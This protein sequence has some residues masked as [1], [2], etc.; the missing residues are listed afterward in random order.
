MID[1]HPASLRKRLRT[2]LG[3]SSP[4]PPISCPPLTF[5]VWLATTPLV[6][7][8]CNAENWTTLT[9]LDTCR[10]LSIEANQVIHVR[11]IALATHPHTSGGRSPHPA[12]SN[13]R[14]DIA[15]ASL[16]T[17]Q[18]K[19]GSR[20]HHMSRSA[21]LYDGKQWGAA[22]VDRGSCVEDSGLQFWLAMAAGSSEICA[23]QRAASEPYRMIGRPSDRALPPSSSH[24]AAK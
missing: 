10:R 7:P 22:F 20:R 18:P 19:S 6:G 24:S 17:T 8:L 23:F 21:R 3:Y 9:G 2:Y 11:P 12:S 15:A 13:G 1:R 16:H 4:P 14:L 5:V